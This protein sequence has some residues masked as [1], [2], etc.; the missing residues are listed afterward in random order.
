MIGRCALPIALLLV[1]DLACTAPLAP[2]A[3]VRSPVL[4]PANAAATPSTAAV[5]PTPT[6]LLMSSEYDLV[7]YSTMIRDQIAELRASVARFDTLV[8][9]PRPRDRAWQ[10]RVSAELATWDDLAQ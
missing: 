8:A 9:T 5:R 7:V 10:E 1:A 3:G 2:S 6:R 4:P